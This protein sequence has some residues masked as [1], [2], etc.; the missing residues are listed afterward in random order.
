MSP[1][2]FSGSSWHVCP[3]VLFFIHGGGEFIKFRSDYV[4]P[5]LYLLSFRF[6][7]SFSQNQSLSAGASWGRLTRTQTPITETYDFFRWLLFCEVAPI[8]CNSIVFLWFLLIC[9]STNML[10]LSVPSTDTFFLRFSLLPIIITHFFSLPLLLNVSYTTNLIIHPLRVVSNIPNWDAYFSVHLLCTYG[11]V[12]STSPD[13]F[14]IPPTHN[15]RIGDKAEADTT[16]HETILHFCALRRRGSCALRKPCSGMNCEWEAGLPFR[17]WC[18]L[19]F[20][21]VSG[22]SSTTLTDRCSNV[23]AHW[24]SV[25]SVPISL[26]SF[27]TL[28]RKR[29]KVEQLKTN[30]T[31]K[32]I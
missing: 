1:F 15:G 13:H 20:L 32:G 24:S 31:E 5:T 29:E 8:R 9:S 19:T 22:F 25:Y 14:H 18:C 3:C 26:S 11:W 4:S 23:Y 2:L 27:E 21:W 17:F 6:A 7:D 30:Q 16:L 10:P 28:S 12:R